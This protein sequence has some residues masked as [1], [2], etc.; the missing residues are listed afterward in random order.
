MLQTSLPDRSCF[1]RV[2]C[3]KKKKREGWRRS[4]S[5]WLLCRVELAVVWPSVL[6]LVLT[7]RPRRGFAPDPVNLIGVLMGEAELIFV[8]NA[9]N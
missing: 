1:T 2:S 4:Q 9:M 8:G 6:T 3:R 7:A 5:D